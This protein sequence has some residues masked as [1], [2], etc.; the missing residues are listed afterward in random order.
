MMTA[1]LIAFVAALFCW[2]GYRL[3]YAQAKFRMEGQR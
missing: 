2:V 3:G 1:V